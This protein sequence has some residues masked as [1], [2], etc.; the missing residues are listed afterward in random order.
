GSRGK[1]DGFEVVK[2]QTITPR[3]HKVY[4]LAYYQRQPLVYIFTMYQ[5]GGEWIINHAHWDDKIE[6]L[7]EAL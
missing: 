4:A 6:R 7:T 2:V 1:Y 5:F 3:L